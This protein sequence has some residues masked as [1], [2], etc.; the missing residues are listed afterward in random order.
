MPKDRYKYF[1]VEA[2]ELLE[3][4]GRGALDL[5]KSAGGV[6]IVV[7]MLRLAHTLK[8][9]ARVVGQPAIAD[10]AH[11]LEDVL[12][13][14]RMGPATA[15]PPEELEQVLHLLDDIGARVAAL[16]G[17]G[18][19]RPPG[20]AAP[21]PEPLE[22]VRVEIGEMDE[23]L[24][25]VFETDV[26]L[27]AIRRDFEDVARARGLAASLVKV[28]PAATRA[29][30]VAEELVSVIDRADR[31]L[32]AGL[33]HAD[34]EIAQVREKAHE[35]RLVPASAVFVELERAARDAAQSLGR[36]VRFETSGGDHRL[37]ANV[38]FAVRD[39]LLHVVRN[40]VAHGIETPADRRR[41]GKPPE[42]LVRLDVK[43]RGHRIAFVCRDDGRGI[44][45]EAVRRVAASRGA[46]V[47]D[48]ELGAEQLLRLLLESGLTT[49][50]KVT[51]VSGRGIGL[52]VLRTTVERLKGDIRLANEPGRGMTVDICV[53]VSL[54]SVSALVLD[55]AGL[56]CC[57]PLDAVRQT[58]RLA[59]GDIA[60][61]A[62][63]DSIVVEGV[64]VPFMPLGRV[65]ARTPSSALVRAWSTVVVE[66]G[67]YRAAIGV[68]RLIG[69][70]RVVLRPLPR[71]AGPVPIAAGASLDGEGNP[72]L[73]LDPRG[74][75]DAVHAGRGATVVAAVEATR[76]PVLIIDDSL[77]TRMLEQSIL[78]SAGYAV[79]LA[80]SAE[81]GLARARQGPY[82]LFLVDVEMPGMD[83][84]EFVAHTRG[85]PALRGIPAILVTSRHSADDRRRGAEVGARAYIVKGEFDQG[86]LL[87]TIR[88]LIG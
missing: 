60:R 51:Q 43:R 2:R 10:C 76:A 46:T 15:M 61:S 32:T 22:N 12:A 17:Q 79:D 83:G 78:E 73:V 44:D 14:H 87:R 33:D 37:E 70:S 13:P 38:L 82:S 30:A 75:V 27:A 47:T 64:V 4:L 50:E 53:P 1:R 21:A 3:G 24:E 59:S 62:E 54:S 80:V 34:H 36:P 5:E 56:T 66:A 68:D 39:A 45:V 67:S 81:E 85:D 23:L 25:G 26:R 16:G 57:V 71:L 74:L 84:F 11:A 86:L 88:L 72:Q 77:T 9:A 28:L 65:L 8:G 63:R 69:T 19:E 18:A 20:T 55:A 58:L 41:A 49:S 48:G 35:L 40:A 6:E 29:R 7:R 31:N 42:G 52:D